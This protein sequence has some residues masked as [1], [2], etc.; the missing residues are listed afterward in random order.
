MCCSDKNGGN[1]CPSA[2]IFKEEFCGNFVGG[3]GPQTVWATSAL[4]EYF[5]GTFQIF[6]SSSS[7]ASVDGLVGLAIGGPTNFPP[8]P[9]GF[10][11]TRSTANPVN[12]TI[13]APAGTS[14]TYCVILYKRVRA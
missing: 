1:C 7:S 11:I 14:G 4:G 13:T 8:V 3:T 5:E 10:T 6:N 2:Q 9:P 12:F